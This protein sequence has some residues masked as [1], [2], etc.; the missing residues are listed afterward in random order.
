VILG[1]RSLVLGFSK[2]T[3]NSVVSVSSF[4]SLCTLW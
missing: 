4:F 2:I 3:K 1:F